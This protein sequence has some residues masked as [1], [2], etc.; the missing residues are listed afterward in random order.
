[1]EVILDC[2]Q[3]TDRESAH[4]YLK[5]RFGFPDHYGRNLDALYD[6]LTE[7][8]PCRAVVR[9]PAALRE[10][11]EY[12]AAILDT[13]YDAALDNPGLEVIDAE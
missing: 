7:L 11:G 3:I 13:I 1:M 6:C 5:A 8:P 4:D 10:M 9:D 2:R 12:G